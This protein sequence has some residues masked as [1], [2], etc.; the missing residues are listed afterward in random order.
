[1]AIKQIMK[2][3]QV[4]TAMAAGVILAACQVSGASAEVPDTNSYWKNMSAAEK[5]AKRYLD[6]AMQSCRG[7]SGVEAEAA[8]K[9]WNIVLQPGKYSGSDFN[10]CSGSGTLVSD[11]IRIAASG[12][13][14][15]KLYENSSLQTEWNFRSRTINLWYGGD[16]ISLSV[17]PISTSVVK[18]SLASLTAQEKSGTSAE[19]ISEGRIV[20]GLEAFWRSAH[21]HYPK[22]SLF[23]IALQVI[24]GKDEGREMLHDFIRCGKSIC[25]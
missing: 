18:A 20:S 2:C 7:L 14:A 15:I 23:D 22:H 9:N 25:E 10:P 12:G 21:D 19:I 17:G 6:D 4:L 1:M 24:T 13:R 3:K 5:V 8:L 11:K 16:H